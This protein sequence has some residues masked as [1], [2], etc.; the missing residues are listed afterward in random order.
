MASNTGSRRLYGPPAS[1]RV[2]RALAKLEATVFMRVRSAESPEAA[3]SIAL[4]TPSMA[5][6]P[7]CCGGPGGRGSHLASAL[8][9]GG[10]EMHATQLGRDDGRHDVVAKLIGSH[11]GGLAVERDVVSV[12]AHTS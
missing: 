4:N 11:F 2:V 3:T 7:V 9:V 10:S 1:V 8:G 5:Q 6:T 12:V